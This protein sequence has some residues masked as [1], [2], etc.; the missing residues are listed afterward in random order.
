MVGR[1][2]LCATRKIS[3]AVVVKI[4]KRD[5]Q[6][7]AA[8]KPDFRF[9]ARVFER[10]VRFLP[11]KPVPV[12]RVRFFRHL[13]FRHIF[14]NLRAIR[15]KNIE[16]AVVV[17]IDQYLRLTNLPTKKIKKRKTRAGAFKILLN[18]TAL[19]LFDFTTRA[20]SLPDPKSARGSVSFRSRASSPGLW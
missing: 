3:A 4:G 5:A 8:R 11:V 7:F 12:F 19:T 16:P 20:H 2:W 18:I 17:E 15:E 10:A 9:F 14:Q 1:T 6:C 13:I